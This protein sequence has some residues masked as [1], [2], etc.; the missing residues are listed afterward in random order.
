MKEFIARVGQ[1]GS[2]ERVR[3]NMIQYSCT[4]DN[5]LTDIHL[6]DISKDIDVHIDLQ[7]EV[8]DSNNSKLTSE[9]NAMYEEL[10]NKQ[11]NENFMQDANKELDLPFR[12]RFKNIELYFYERIAQL[13]SLVEN[14]KKI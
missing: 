3:I 8:M 6:E 2:M 13:E 14:T 1:L 5:G 11:M 7:Y 12:Q 10:R 9:I 4:C